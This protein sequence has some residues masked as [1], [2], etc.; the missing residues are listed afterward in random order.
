MKRSQILA[1]TVVALMVLSAF[2]AQVAQAQGGYTEKLNVFVAGSDALWYFT[3]GGVNGSTGLS[4]LES[5]PGLNWYNVTA[6]RT[7]GWQSDFQVFGPKGYNLL[8]VH[9]VPPQGM[10]LTVGSDSYADASAAAT[11]LD[12]YLETTFVSLSNGTGTY[13]FYS[14]LS[15]NQLIPA[16]L[17]SLLPTSEGGFTSALTSTNLISSASPFVV[18]EGTKASS[19]FSHSLVVGSIVGSAL[20]TLGVPSITSYFGTTLS[21]ITASNH[22]SSSVIQL[23]FLDGVVKSTDS[24]DVTNNFASFTGSYTLSLAPG[25][26]VSKI[27]AT[28]SEQPAPLLA[29]RAVDTGVLRTN[30]VLAVTLK[31]TNLSP[32]YTITRVSFSDDW[33]NKT[34]GFKLLGGNYTVPTTALSA[35]QSVTP[36]Y[37]LQYTGTA[38]GSVTIPA[39]VVRY[40]YEVGTAVFN[41]TALLNP[42]RLSLGTD[43]AVVYAIVEPIGS[44]GKSVGTPQSF[45]VTVTN[46]GTLPA[47]SVVVAGH[48]IAGLAAKSGGSAGGMASVT[49]SQSAAGLLGSN[50]TRSYLATYQ[51]P[52]GASLNATTNVISD[53]FSHS[54]MK[55]GFPSLTVNAQLATLPN[56][57]TNLTL[58]F[59]T[60]NSGP[61]NVTSFSATGSL[62]AGLGCGAV[63]GK[64]LTCS[65]GRVSIS[66]PVIN[67]SGTL[68]AYMKYNLTS[69]L[70][71]FIPPLSFGGMTAGNNATGKSNPVAVPSGLVLTKL[72]SPAQL[73]G[74]MN[75]EVTVAATNAGP[76]QIYN[77]SV[78]TSVDN[79][80]SLNGQASLTKKASSLAPGANTNFT[81]GVTAQLVSGNLTAK[82]VTASLFFGG[83]SYSVVG[84]SPK[85]QVYQPVRVSISTTPATPE[86]GKT[87]KVNF[88]VVNPSGVPVT[89]VLFVLP[90]PSGLGLSN[91]QNAQVSGGLLTI[92]VGNLAAHSTANASAS[93]VASSGIVIPFDK[94]KL[95][96]SYG[97]V[98]I[99]G[100]LP[101]KSGIGIAEDVTTRYLIPIGIILVV[102][103]G[104][105]YYVRRKAV[106]SA[107]SSPK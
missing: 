93:G 98:T 58:S 20:S 92:S 8:P 9:S 26:H 101:S 13:S 95:T 57:G 61:V 97:G 79:F 21:S 34:T 40:T 85:V 71:Y 38:T 22:S 76:M 96:F 88:Q 91:L 73:F 35:G 18:L 30:D 46:V 86:E 49:V 90:V 11:A 82:P 44:F 2:P 27:N 24:A 106:P 74:G 54:T 33:W 75:S 87:F 6:I 102:L 60:A 64:G 69:P 81:Y 32:T 17:F 45:N 29:T 80:D 39:S 103:L 100:V 78:A 65:G 41:A 37:R 84:V 107:P 25:K 53:V 63:S 72:F 99:N 7:T 14:S 59:A 42:I 12:S 31:L 19:G 104:T 3:F 67:A 83:I 94:A 16:T 51:D 52:A 47:S 4:T 105:A 48:S 55:V 70:N 50:V 15:F 43:D 56:M 23:R 1:A 36:V 28:V 10:F 66:Y 77:V 68:N 62:P 5:T 89:N